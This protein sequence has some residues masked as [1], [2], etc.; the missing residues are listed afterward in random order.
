[1]LSIL[2]WGRPPIFVHAMPAI[3]PGGSNPPQRT[4]F[5]PPWVKE[6][7]DTHHVPT[8]PWTLARNRDS[9]I[10]S[11]MGTTNKPAVLKGRAATENDA[12][13]ASTAIP[14]TLPNKGNAQ[15]SSATPKEPVQV[16]KQSKITIIPSMPSSKPKE[17]GH[18]NATAVTSKPKEDKTIKPEEF[19]RKSSLVESKPKSTVV[20]VKSLEKNKP[21]KVLERT[22][23]IDKVAK[24]KPPEPTT[25]PPAPPMPPPPPPGMKKTESKVL[26]PVIAEKLE[27]LKS[28]PRKRPDWGAMMKA[29]ETGK[30]LKHVQCNDRSSPL[31]ACEKVKEQFM[32]ESEKPN[33][34]NQLLKQI[35]YG[36]QLK[37]VQ[38]ND[39]SRPLLD[40]LRKF[41]RQLTIEE[42]IQK[43][44]ETEEAVVEVDELDDI[45]KVRD[46][47][48]STKQMLALELR[49]K[50]AVERENKR[51]LARI[52]NLEVEIE[53]EKN[54]KKQ[55]DRTPQVLKKEHEEETKKLQSE[56]RESQHAVEKIENKYHDTVGQLDMTK[57]DL[58]DALRKNQQLERKLA[59]IA[60]KDIELLKNDPGN[61]QSISPKTPLTSNYGHENLQPTFESPRASTSVS[62]QPPFPELFTSMTSQQST[63]TAQTSTSKTPQ[64]STPSTGF[65]HTIITQVSPVPVA[66][67]QYEEVTET[68]TETES[69]EED[70]TDQAALQERRT[71]RELKLLVT[72]LKSFKEKE[73]M[74]R[75][76]RHALRE[77]LKKQ[78]QA[79]RDEKKNYKK[80]QKEVDKMA[81]LMKDDDENDSE[82]EEEGESEEDETESES[83]SEESEQEESEGELPPDTPLDKKKQNL[84]ERSKM[85]ENCLA[86]LKKGN[87]LLK[88]NID[89]LKDDLFKQREMSLTLQ[90]DLNSVLAEL[91]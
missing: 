12:T 62:P 6:S 5:R 15:T 74:A 83:E 85:H 32:Y 39:R 28:R 77:Q 87:Y 21:N 8:A 29:I 1:M 16:R 38:C 44:A 10:A 86:A 78:Q 4:T 63:S 88:A 52:L 27:T 69:S 14:K 57:N 79:L 34:H 81:K 76:E 72:K 48:Q 71:A 11:N 26:P 7:P 46:D 67:E 84:T 90:E 31:L 49:N 51:L 61:L 64:S 2:L 56:L 60:K 65:F 58:E 9:G 47:L 3:N 80:L 30:K 45:D 70:E 55:E 68:E 13:A 17:N 42:Q 20:E 36:V 50:E 40:G 25:K 53:K 35:Q 73:T 43:A 82:S 59:S 33:V 23:S 24:E 66:A 75:K 89:K 54:T 18:Q 19:K 91:G 41:R 22:V 37:R